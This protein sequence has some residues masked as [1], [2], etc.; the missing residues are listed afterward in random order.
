MARLFGTVGK[1]LHPDRLGPIVAQMSGD[2]I[3]VDHRVS[4]EERGFVGVR[5]G[6]TPGGLYCDEGMSVAVCGMPRIT[7]AEALPVSLPDDVGRGF[8]ASYRKRGTESLTS[9]SG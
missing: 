1:S 3:G 9:L 2:G 4:I 7:G 5:Q 6:V 8:M